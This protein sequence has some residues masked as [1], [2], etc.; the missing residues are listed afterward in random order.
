[1]TRRPFRPPVSLRACALVASLALAGCS[2]KTTAPTGNGDV[3][4][5]RLVAF[6]SDRGQSTGLTSIYLWDYDSLAFRD[7]SGLNVSLEPRHHPSVSPD[8]RFVAFDVSR[9][10]QY[11]VEVYDRKLRQTDPNASSA[12]NTGD[13]ESE[14]TFTGDGHLLCFTQGRTA[15]RIRLFDGPTSRFIALPGL[16]TVSTA[17]SDWAPSPNY[18]GSLIAFVSDR[19]GNPDIYLYDRNRHAVLDGTNLRNALVSGGADVDP[20]FSTSGRYLTFASD[21]GG[22]YDLFLLE[23]RVTTSTTDTLFS[24]LTAA[25]SGSDERH[26]AINDAGSVVVF[27]SNRIGQGR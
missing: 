10:G 21:R 8:G 7:L 1:M 22:N 14:P 9:N 18:N 12:I 26:P 6:A 19:R 2:S 20:R 16:D 13:D 24:T 11:D 27:Q 23:F 5:I 25:N 15:R 4:G 3:G 17:Y